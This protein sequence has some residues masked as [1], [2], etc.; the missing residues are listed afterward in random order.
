MF[1]TNSPFVKAVLKFIDL[2]LL[3]ALWVMTCIP[4]MTIG[5][6][7]AA[8]LDVVKR[9][10]FGGDGSVVVDYFRA[11]RGNGKQA[12]ITGLVYALIAA[13]LVVDIVMLR[14][15]L[16]SGSGLGNYWLIPL[17]LLL[18]A[19]SVFFWVCAHIAFFR[20]SLRQIVRNCFMLSM[21]HFPI[22]IVTVVL[23]ALCGLCV[24][25]YPGTLFLAPVL[26]LLPVCYLMDRAFSNYIP[27]EKDE[28]ESEADH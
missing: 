1:H 4:V 2:L 10:I 7:T 8:A 15:L 26:F 11:L 21:M 23:G 3:N 12:F 9:D 25:I 14:T 27:E 6:A 28:A 19:T 5:L 17:L 18:F 16:Q 20:Q 24:W 22:S 13:V